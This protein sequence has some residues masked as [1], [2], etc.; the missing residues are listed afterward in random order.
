MV[1]TILL[2]ILGLDIVVLVHE[3]GH[4]AAAKLSG[5]KVEAFSIGMG[6]KLLYFNYR[7]TEYRISILPI[8]GYCKMKGEEEFS[9]A[10]K[11]KAKEIPREEGSLFSV[12]PL[13]RI[14]TYFAGPF[15]N[16]IFSVIVLSAIWF[17]GFTVQT[18]SN[19]IVLISD[20][21]GIFHSTDNPADRAGMKTGDVI[22]S[23]DGTKVDNYSDI[24]QIIYKSPE[25]QLSVS[26]KRGGEIRKLHITPLL[27]KDTGAGKIGISPFIEPVVEAVN[28]DSA[29][30]LAGLSSGDRIIEV[31][32][33]KVSNYLDIISA[34]SS[35]PKIL[36][37]K[38]KSS[39]GS[40]SEK[41]LVPIYSEDGT[42]DLGIAFKTESVNKGGKGLFNSMANGT[43]ETV[44]NLVMTVKSL[45]LLFSGVNLGKAVSGPIRI[46]YF[47]GEVATEGFKNG[48]KSGL[49]TLFRFLSVIS[50]ALCFANLLP[51]P[52]FDGGLI[53]FT[54]FT[55]I[56]R[57]PVN[58]SVYYKYQ[59][60]GIVII[61]ILF[62]LTTFSDIS[63]LFSKG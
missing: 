36:K 11:A 7:G 61:L 44:S 21:P 8:G 37:L 10:L 56:M 52:I 40:I 6:K 63:F 59:S 5:I 13:K 24:Q 34:M 12:S 58:P 17:F 26:V 47:V 55:V 62:M 18:Y 32:G 25:K 30:S 23:I 50:I 48:V 14:A 15:A 41:I 46:T 38:V 9:R 33:K 2:G 45:G 20:Y 4:F 60:A 3:L 39:E 43:K 28:P 53:L 31:N 57:V 16:F 54:L 29:G 35:N 51:I 27:D 22:V 19:R 42:A 1:S 49:T